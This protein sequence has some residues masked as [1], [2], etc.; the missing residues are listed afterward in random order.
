M[1]IQD[2]RIEQV[3]NKVYAELMKWIYLLIVISF[4]A[5]I[6][7]FK[8]EFSQCITEY[9]ILIGTPIYQGIRSR[10]LE[11]V[12][13]KYPRE[14]MN[15][16]REIFACLIALV[17]FALFWWNSGKQVSSEFAI[18]YILVFGIVFYLLRTVFARIERSKL[19]KLEKEYEDE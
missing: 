4:V 6:L 3:R 2:E 12:L 1:K 8:M 5:K 19:E 18:G 7:Y 17:V 9:I 10:Q 13:P 16:K 15:W 11:V 14:K